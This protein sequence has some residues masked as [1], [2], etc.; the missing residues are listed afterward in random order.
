MGWI[1]CRASVSVVGLSAS[2]G[3]SSGVAPFPG[4]EDDSLPERRRGR[5]RLFLSY[6]TPWPACQRRPCKRHRP[7]RVAAA[8]PSQ[9]GPTG[10]FCHRTGCD[11]VIHSHT[12][13]P[14]PSCFRSSRASVRNLARPARSAAPAGRPPRRVLW[15]GAQQWGAPAWSA[16]TRPWTPGPLGLRSH[17]RA[18]RPECGRRVG[19]E[20]P[21]G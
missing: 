13:P 14:K 16:V 15:P 17:P 20:P 5:G 7:D 9:A 11:R 1:I 12:S 18:T 4:V 2:A 19:S 8:P 21:G 6:D 10:P 3:H